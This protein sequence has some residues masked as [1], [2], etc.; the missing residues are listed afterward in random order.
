METN[1][2]SL[3]HRLTPQEQLLWV[4]LTMA[5]LSS[6]KVSLTNMV[7]R[8]KPSAL[9]VS[10]THSFQ[11]G[12]QLC[13]HIEA[14][15]R[16]MWPHTLSHSEI[17]SALLFL[18]ASFC[19]SVTSFIIKNECLSSHNMGGLSA[20]CRSRES[21]VKQWIQL[22]INHLLQTY[23]TVCQSNSFLL[24][25]HPVYVEISLNAPQLWM[26]NAL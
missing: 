24:A 26:I 21:R 18:F 8:A 17:T 14:C 11:R 6:A 12:V 19:Q 7:P 1:R 22:L 13:K 25:F 10:L 20:T 4:A 3:A 2:M 5:L 16:K 9:S 23:V 15:S